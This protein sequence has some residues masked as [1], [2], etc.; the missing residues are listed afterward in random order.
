MCD[1]AL[2]QNG[3]VWSD[4][5]KMLQEHHERVALQALGLMLPDWVMGGGSGAM[6]GMQQVL[7]RN[8]KGH[9]PQGTGGDKEME[10]KWSGR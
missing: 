10:S 6:L 2:S 5:V 9:V 3:V 4:H 7:S 8:I 1:L